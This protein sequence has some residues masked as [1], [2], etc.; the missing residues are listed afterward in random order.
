VFI[1]LVVMMI[2][3][4]WSDEKS[5]YQERV[6]IIDKSMFRPTG[7]FVVGSVLIIGILTA[8]Y[9]VFW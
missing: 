1:F 4:T 7:A 9:T 6:I 8:L 5:Q 2:A 3:V